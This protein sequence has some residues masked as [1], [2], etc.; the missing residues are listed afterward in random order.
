MIAVLCAKTVYRLLLLLILFEMF[1]ATTFNLLKNWFEHPLVL[2]RQ[3]DPA[4]LAAALECWYRNAELLEECPTELPTA[5][6]FR[7]GQ[8]SM[9]EHA[10]YIAS[11]IRRDPDPYPAPQP[12]EVEANVQLGTPAY[13]DDAPYAMS[14]GE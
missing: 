13:S 6:H 4:L 5:K 12:P 2:E 9:L 10:K 8:G 3:A 11:Q 14:Y 1:T 7:Y